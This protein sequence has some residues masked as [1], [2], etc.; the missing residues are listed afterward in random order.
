MYIPIIVRLI[1]DYS[2][3]NYNLLK[4]AKNRPP[5]SLLEN[6]C[7]ITMIAS[8]AVTLVHKVVSGTEIFLLQVHNKRVL[9]EEKK[10][11]KTI[12]EYISLAMSVL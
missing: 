7:L 10:K 9:Y 3:A 4:K 5:R 1:L 12:N 2:T 8:Y 11:K 6:I